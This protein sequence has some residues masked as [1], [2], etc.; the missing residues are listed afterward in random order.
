MKVKLLVVSGL[1]ASG[2]VTANSIA[3]PDHAHGDVPAS[4]ASSA[5]SVT[6]IAF[7]P[8]TSITYDDA[9]T[10]ATGSAF[11]TELTSYENDGNENTTTRAGLRVRKSSVIVALQHRLAIDVANRLTDPDKFISAMNKILPAD[12]A[13]SAE[14][15][16]DLDTVVISAV[17]GTKDVISDLVPNSIHRPVV[18][19]D[20][21]FTLT[22][23]PG[24]TIGAEKAAQIILAGQTKVKLTDYRRVDQSTMLAAKTA[25]PVTVSGKAPA[26][27]TY[28]TL[29]KALD[30]YFDITDSSFATPLFPIWNVNPATDKPVFINQANGE[31]V[32][33]SLNAS[34]IN[35]LASM[36]TGPDG[37]GSGD[38]GKARIERA[39]EKVVF[40]PAQGRKAEDKVTKSGS[41]YEGQFDV[42]ITFIQ[43]W[44]WDK[45]AYTDRAAD[46]TL[47][48]VPVKVMFK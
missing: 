13:L 46:F 9:L 24:K 16:A 39:V 10:T 41:S 35:T 15:L 33:H 32:K 14:D 36:Y 8:V 6:R 29:V 5:A 48:N 12:S 43:H 3:A 37:K 7:K 19:L 4:V 38:F 18:D 1:L 11:K 27:V 23:K 28:E 26:K 22:A 45:S 34:Q 47:K 25:V 42:T 40:T 17:P 2:L 20:L 21:Q 30:G 44:S 31:P